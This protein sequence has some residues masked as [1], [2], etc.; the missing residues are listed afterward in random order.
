MHLA[1]YAMHAGPIALGLAMTLAAAPAGLVAGPAAS[2]QAPAAANAGF[3]S[4][5][6]DMIVDGDGERLVMR[7]YVDGSRSRTEF[8]VDGEVIVTIELGDAAHTTYTIVPSMK[9]VMKSTQPREALSATAPTSG[10]ASTPDA[11]DDGLELVGT[12]TID[13]RPAEKYRVNAADGDGFVWVDPS[14]QLAVRM[15]AGGSRVDMRNY[16]FSKPAPELF[17]IPK[18]YDV[19]DI[20]E[21]TRRINPA[22]MMAGGVA[23]A[24]AAQT[25]GNLGGD[26][27]ASIGGAFGPLGSMIGRFLGQKF[28]RELGQKAATAI[29]N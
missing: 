6:V 21:M 4:Y 3:S 1:P 17:E 16:D 12:E 25:A 9:R 20:D 15:E 11:A 23:G 13:G 10:A 7:R 24:Y 27:G 29:V 8:D 5:R 19:M 26:L 22:R 28:G 2:G 14:T 18:G